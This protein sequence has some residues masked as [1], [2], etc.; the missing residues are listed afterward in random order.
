MWIRLLSIL[1][2]V[3]R[4]DLKLL[5]MNN[6]K[7][8]KPL[9]LAH[10][11]TKMK[12]S[13]KTSR[14]RLLI[15][16]MLLIKPELNTSMT[17]TDKN[18]LLSNGNKLRLKE[19]KFKQTFKIEKLSY[20]SGRMREEMALKPTPGLKEMNKNTKNSLNLPKKKTQKIKLL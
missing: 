10:G 20:K 8:T 2:M 19:K 6:A 11:L 4:R 15:N 13:I 5:K 18:S 7:D 3:T 1:T 12:F 14:L 9:K 16:N 17:S